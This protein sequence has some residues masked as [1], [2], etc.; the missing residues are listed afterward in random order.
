[1]NVQ[2]CGMLAK[3]GLPSRLSKLLKELSD[4][5]NRD[6]SQIDGPS[7][8]PYP[9]LLPTY[10]RSWK[11]LSEGKVTNII[12]VVSPL[13]PLSVA[14]ILVAL[15]WRKRTSSTDSKT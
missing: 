11:Y 14:G 7:F 9:G 1:M 5:H 10:A 6:P 3:S 8:M 13:I 15:M 2:L 12:V 4:I